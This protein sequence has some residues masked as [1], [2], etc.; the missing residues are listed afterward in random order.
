MQDKTVYYIIC[1]HIRYST[2]EAAGE[3]LLDDTTNRSGLVS[4]LM[5]GVSYFPR[6]LQ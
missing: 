3:I 5:Q 2:F 6:F 1:V 4:L